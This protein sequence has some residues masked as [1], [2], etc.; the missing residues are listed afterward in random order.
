MIDRILPWLASVVIR[1][2]GWTTR[3]RLEGLERVRPELD[4]G[5]PVLFFSWHETALIAVRAMTPLRPVIMVSQS[6]DGERIARIVESLG[7]RAVRGSS[8]RGGVRALLGVV[9]ELRRGRVACHLVDGPRGP[10]R[11]VKPGLLLMGQRSGALMAP[12]YAAS[13]GVWRAHSWDRMPV[14]L[15]FGWTR[16]Q[17]GRPFRVP[18]DLPETEREALRERVEADLE[19]GF[20]RLRREARKTRARK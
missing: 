10:A 9:R 6:R 15:P 18:A 16:L 17:L 2:I 12:I 20:E 11:R 5:R 13:G 19:A 7:W 3:T 4:A 1:A 14:P 8:S